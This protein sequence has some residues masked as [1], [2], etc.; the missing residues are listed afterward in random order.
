MWTV[1]NFS[2]FSSSPFL[3]NLS[4]SFQ[5]PQ[6][7]I[8]TISGGPPLLP[9]SS[10]SFQCCVSSIVRSFIVFVD[11]TAWVV[12]DPARSIVLMFHITL[13]YVSLFVLHIHIQLVAQPRM[14]SQWII[15]KVWGL[16]IQM[17]FLDL[18][19]LV[20]FPFLCDKWHPETDRLELQ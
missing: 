8:I 15:V 5:S 19:L 1:L 18:F 16:W 20:L 11:Q 6:T 2:N 3:T 10:E 12:E 9:S 7:I 13:T 4:E 14:R 17:W